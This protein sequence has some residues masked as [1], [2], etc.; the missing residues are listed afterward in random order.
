[1]LKVQK[2]AIG[3]LNNAAFD[4]L[5]HE[6]Q[7]LQRKAPHTMLLRAARLVKMQKSMDKVNAT[8]ELNLLLTHDKNI[9][10]L[11]SEPKVTWGKWLFNLFRKIHIFSFYMSDHGDPESASHIVNYGRSY[12]EH[13]LLKHKIF[14]ARKAALNL[15][16]GM[17]ELNSNKAREIF[18]L[19]HFIVSCLNGVK[20][21]VAYRF[22]FSK[23]EAAGESDIKQYQRYAS[24]IF[25]PIYFL[26][27]CLYVYL[28][29]VR[30]GA[31]A[32]SI[33]L[34][35]SLLSVSQ[36]IIILSPFKIWM[37]GIV[38][39]AIASNDVRT[40]H[41]LLRERAKY[42][43][44][45]S[46]GLIRY[47][48][49]F[50][51][52]FNPACRAARAFP[53]L[54]ISRLLMSLN[55]HDLPTK[56]VHIEGDRSGIL[57]YTTATIGLLF[58]SLM[59]FLTLAPEIFQDSFIEVIVTAAVNFSVMAMG[60]LSN[61]SISIPIAV[62]L[63]LLL[64]AYLRERYFH[65]YMS[66]LP[67]MFHAIPIEDEWINEDI[68]EKE[69]NIA[70]LKAMMKSRY[71]ELHHKTYGKRRNALAINS[72]GLDNLF[73]GVRKLKGLKDKNE[74]D[75]DGYES[76]DVST[77]VSTQAKLHRIRKVIP[78]EIDDFPSNADDNYFSDGEEKDWI[79]A[80]KFKSQSISTNQGYTP[81]ISEKLCEDDDF[82]VYD[83][84]TIPVRSSSNVKEDAAL[85]QG[86]LLNQKYLELY[87]N[88]E[89]TT[90]NNSGSTFIRAPYIRRRNVRKE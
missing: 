25:L 80:S 47:S 19:Q 52:H 76:E 11:P 77:K 58:A 89:F 50:I 72:D 34:N 29:G 87:E 71:E 26:F 30:I 2:N 6:L 46:R 83:T 22:F 54:A 16:K 81:R 1:M 74:Y 3:D 84:S 44:L 42:I 60:I 82:N 8:K 32:T 28:F 53:E 24:C 9:W 73:A 79:D 31:K 4:S 78:D 61:L 37:R 59:F 23:F 10:E 56:F 67:K 62:G 64:T 69:N 21:K 27:V 43:T 7:D 51:Q 48:N 40:V 90:N 36:D 20:K 88:G 18:L 63:F 85:L 57:Y 41:A 68:K 5:P 12:E 49:S 38:V 14:A 17:N 35:G 39:A 66:N 70:E 86:A 13:G 45:R 65:R 15:K 55:D 75:G 33:W